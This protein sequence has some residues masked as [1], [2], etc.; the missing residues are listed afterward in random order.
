MTSDDDSSDDGLLGGESIFAGSSRA[1]ARKEKKSEIFLEDQLAK[2]AERTERK[3]R[4]ADALHAEK[5]ARA[6]ATAVAAAA[7]ANG[8][9]NADGGGAGD[10]VGLELNGSN[11]TDAASI[12]VSSS[13]VSRKR[14]G[15]RPT[16]DD[17]DPEYWKR[18]HELSRSSGNTADGR[19]KRQR[20]IREKVDGLDDVSDEEKGDGG[21]EDMRRR[22]ALALARDVGQSTCLGA[23]R[24][25]LPAAT[26]VPGTTTIGDSSERTTLATSDL[27][28]GLG[29]IRIFASCVV[30]MTELNTIIDSLI[31]TAGKRGTA[32]HKWVERE[33]RDC[34]LKSVKAASEG[35]SVVLSQYLSEKSLVMKCT[36]ASLPVPRQLIVWLFTSSCSGSTI[37]TLASG[38]YATLMEIMSAR[39]RIMELGQQG[40]S[41]CGGPKVAY[42]SDLIPGLERLFRL[43][44]QDGPSPA[45]DTSDDESGNMK[46]RDKRPIKSYLDNASGLGN[47][48]SLWA[49]A[50][51]Y[52]YIASQPLKEDMSK[53]VPASVAA[54]V[55]AGLD[56]I[57]QSGRQLE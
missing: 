56:P 31:E 13:S 45:M 23:R 9:D 55:R 30:A 46:K 4:I 17:D 43:W 49:A 11:S 42:L 44:T 20:E 51:N 40:E 1:Q 52:N 19:A 8:A 34:I 27:P 16:Y 50:L 5:E 35:G 33:V 37:R 7:A 21:A 28:F 54:L 18:A 10:G 39:L 15:K 24:M 32:E 25:F 14:S 48:L 57:F 22:R 47:F 6:R 2:E 3:R 36:E 41:P 29:S 38:A 53:I 26:D 12:G